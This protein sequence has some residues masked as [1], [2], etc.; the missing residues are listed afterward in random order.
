MGS[1]ASKPHLEYSRRSLVLKSRGLTDLP[2]YIPSGHR[3]ETLDISSNKIRELPIFLPHLRMLDYSNNDLKNLSR[4]IE[5]AILSYSEI[6][7]LRLASN[8]LEKI[9]SAFS[10]L[11]TL[12]TLILSSNKLKKFD[13]KFPS[14]E[15]LDV[16]CNLIQNFNSNILPES[17]YFLNL[18]FNRLCN[19]E[20][21]SSNLTEL[22]LS[23]ND[24]TALP[25]PNSVKFENLMLLNISYNKLRSINNLYQLAPK[26]E[27]L[28]ASF[29]LID[30]FPDKLPINIQ[31]LLIDY[32][33]LTSMKPLND[34][35]KLIVLRINNNYL[36][37]LSE[38]PQSLQQLSAEY[39]RIE[40]VDSIT[41]NELQQ[42][43]ISQ[44]SLTEVPMFTQ[45]SIISFL[46]S[47]NSIREIN[48][49]QFP[50]TIVKIEL[51]LNEIEAVPG[52]LFLLPSL[53]QLYLFGNKISE[54]PSEIAHSN[55]QLLNISSNP[56]S[57]LPK[58]PKTLAIFTAQDCQF[59]KFPENLLF[60]PNI[61]S[62]DFSNN[63]I[64]SVPLLPKAE[65]L[66]FSCNCITTFPILPEYIRELDLSHNKIKNATIK[67]ANKYLSELDLSFNNLQTLT[68]NNLL[69]ALTSLKISNNPQLDFFFTFDSF[70]ELKC[71]DI[72][73]TNV[74][75]KNSELSLK[76]EEIIRSKVYSHSPLIKVFDA[77]NAGYAEMKGKRDFMEDSLIL[78]HMTTHDI[79]AVIDGH[80][81]CLTST[82]TAFKLSYN[83]KTFSVNDLVSSLHD[84]N[85]FLRSK[86]VQDGATLALVMKCEKEIIA[87]NIGDSRALI[88]KHNGSIFPLSYDHKPYER[89][90]LEEI[91]NRGTYI[92]HMRTSGILAIS[93]S[94]GDFA[95][96]G[97]TATPCI[98]EYTLGDDDYRLVIACDGVFDVMSNEEVGSM[99]ITEESPSVAAYK[100][101]NAAYARLSEDNISVIVVDL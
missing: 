58:L 99:V 45:S 73:N 21:A 20:F 50:Q 38:L 35:N 22:I 87:A 41:L 62:V 7:E 97:V 90:E 63:K 37:N 83:L 53:Q 69:P 86:D 5:K 79:F 55:L 67:V 65:T 74:V 28:N 101:R 89:S 27:I 66:L 2:V 42:L 1:D 91:R 23:G 9:P 10:S 25:S 19:I 14:L 32:N 57:K 18:S 82:L 71:L 43:T 84:L 49:S 93:R 36:Q 70:P 76:I 13:V 6:D 52:A 33:R 3:I 95:L 60:L 39:N 92:S 59:T 4:S 30:E 24:I 11:S 94:L 56:I 34:Y 16:S 72:S 88:V 44:N 64:P 96:A 31:V 40:D 51:S 98:T 48:V 68:C 15:I 8:G 61:I 81:G 80:A 29:N 85:N 100:I 17:I 12:K 47:Y 75:L 54:L 46:A 78:R 77:L 26:I